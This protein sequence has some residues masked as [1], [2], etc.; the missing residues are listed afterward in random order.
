MIFY[1]APNYNPNLVFE[2]THGYDIRMDKHMYDNPIYKLMSRY[3]KSNC[4]NTLH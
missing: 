3:I 1:N 2:G 4:I